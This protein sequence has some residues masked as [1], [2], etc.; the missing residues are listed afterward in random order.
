MS[1]QNFKI[2]LNEYNRSGKEKLDGYSSGILIGLEG[3][4]RQQAIKMLS[5]EAVSLGA[6]IDALAILDKDY[7]LDL[8][9][10]LTSEVTPSPRET[11]KYL[12]IW[13]LEQ[14]E[15]N[16]NSY[17]SCV[18]IKNDLL[19]TK[20]LS[21]IKEFPN[22]SCTIN[23]LRDVII[24]NDDLINK[25]IAASEL[26]ERGHFTGDK[27]PLKYILKHGSRVEKNALIEKLSIPILV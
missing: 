7:T 23:F 1:S 26:L 20:A 4:E 12:W 6:A 21:P 25:G 18:D 19:V 24:Y 3:E 2:F 22:Y 16:A 27:G 11:H 17:F 8:L 15:S 9:K 14:T 10:K 13:R 5:E